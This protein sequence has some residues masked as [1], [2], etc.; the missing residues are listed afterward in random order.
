MI[1][2]LR[3]YIDGIQYTGSAEENVPKIKVFVF[4]SYLFLQNEYLVSFP[5]SFG[6]LYIK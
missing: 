3:F 5:L 2:L 4:V 1:I 6:L